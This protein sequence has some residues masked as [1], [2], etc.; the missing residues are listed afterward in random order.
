MLAIRQFLEALEGGI[1]G[2]FRSELDVQRGKTLTQ[3]IAPESLP[4]V[5]LLAFQP[6]SSARIIS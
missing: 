6:T 2:F 3:C 1:E 4:K 5:S